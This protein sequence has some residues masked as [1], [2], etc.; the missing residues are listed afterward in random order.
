[1]LKINLNSTVP[2]Y[3]QLVIEIKRMIDERILEE[4]D[5]LPTIRSLASQLDVAINTVARAYQELD[6][7]GLIKSRGRK[8]TVVSSHIFRLE[9]AEQSIF[10]E[11]IRAL[12]QK[13]LDRS[14]IENLFK[15][16]VSLF[17]D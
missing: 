13:G 11:P 9:G 15:S 10:K 1:M 5:S 17:F 14:D 16:N 3:E 2:I 6:S 12:L 4:G 8:G 7:M